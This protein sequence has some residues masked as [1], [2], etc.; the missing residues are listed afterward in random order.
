MSASPGRRKLV[1]A[2]GLGIALAGSR[3]VAGADA[4]RRLLRTADVHPEDYPTVQAV[5]AMGQ[6]LQQRTRGR[7]GI[8]VFHSGLL[9]DEA[10]LLDLV[11]TG[12]LD[13]NRINVQALESRASLAHVLSLPYLF[14]DTEHLHKV[15]DGPLGKEILDSLEPSGLIGLAFY[16]AGVRNVYSARKPIERLE[17]F[18]NLNIRVQPSTMATAYFAALLAT[19]VAL[20]YAQTGR[21]LNNRIVD[22]AENNLPAYGSSEH[23]RAAPYYTLT[24]HFIQPD[25]LVI[26]RATWQSLSPAEQTALRESARAS[27]TVMRDMWQQREERVE[28][29]LKLAGVR[30]NEL[31]PAELARLRQAAQAIYARFAADP[32]QQ[33]LIKRI[34]AVQ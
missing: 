4:P 1:Q 8:Q 26:S 20:P 24:R 19:P 22:A 29:S 10:P 5:L 9:G 31:P 28:A 7:L 32:R 21:A 25:V 34:R 13:M 3:A 30:F 17:D 2:L 23:Y 14:R 15:I 6:A 33:E 27:V 12:K 11:Q 16:D 18:R